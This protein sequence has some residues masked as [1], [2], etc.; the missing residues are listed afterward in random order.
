MARE[1]EIWDTLGIFWFTY[2]VQKCTFV[3]GALGSR[4]NDDGSLAGF[5]PIGRH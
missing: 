3:N 5:L 4:P 2:Y 1:R